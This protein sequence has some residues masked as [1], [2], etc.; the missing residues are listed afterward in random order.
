MFYNQEIEEV[1]QQQQTDAAKGLSNAEVQTRKEKYGPNKLEEGKKKSLVVLFLQQL[2]DPLIFI[3]IIA[4]IVSGILGELNDTIIIA[5]VV[6]LNAILG[7]SQ[8]AKAEKAMEALQKLTSPKAYVVRDGETVEVDSVEIVPGDIVVLDAG[9]YIPCD[10]RLIESINMQVEESALTGESVPVHKNAKLVISDENIPLGDKKNMAF[11]STLVTSGRGMGVAIAI[12]METE[13]GHIANMLKQ[14]DQK[15]PLQKKLADIGKILG[16]I[17]LGVCLAMFLIAVFQHRDIFQMFMIAISLAVAAIPEGMP[18]IVSIVLA[19]GVQ[20]MVKKNAIVRK[21][22]SVETLGAVTV[23][24]SD[25][26]GTLTQ[27]KMTVRKFYVNKKVVAAEEMDINEMT[28]RLLIENLVLCSDATSN[29]EGSTGDP[30][31][32]A[33]INIGNHYDIRKEALTAEHQ[34]IHEAPFDSDRK[35]MS[36]INRYGDKYYVMTKGATDNLLHKSVKALINGEVVPMTDEIRKDFNDAAGKMSDDAL[37]VLGAACKETME[38]DLDMEQMESDLIFLGLVAMIDPPRLEVRDSISTCRNSGII[39]VMITGDHQKTAFAIAK[40]LGIADRPEQTMAGMELDKYSDEELV[41]KV[42][43]IRVF[44]RVSPEH[45]VRIVTAY[46]GGGNI[47]SMTGDGVNDAPSLKAAD[48]GV[49][50]GITGTDVAKGASDL[51]LTDDN[52]STIV[53]AVEEGRNIYANIKKSVMFLLSCNIGE[54]VSL[55]FAVLLGWATPLQSIHLLWVNLI[56]D[57]FPALSLGADPSDPTIMKE[58]PRS[59]KESLFSGRG[60]FLVINGV[61]IGFITLAAFC[62]GGMEYTGV[63]NLSVLHE[64]NMTEDVLRHAQTMAFVVLSVSQLFHALNLRSEKRSIFQV[65]LF[66]NKW[67][68]LSIVAGILIQLIIISVP[69]LAAVFEVHALSV[70]DWALVIG[71]SLVPLILN[72]I[73]KLIRRMRSK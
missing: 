57:S 72:E 34:R 37:R 3:L 58:K 6:I 45:K 69:A 54:I 36:T 2:N 71:L 66:T 63:W 9:R 27:N 64:G 8:E 21:L 42:K 44:A 26:T 28:Q 33:L 41:E 62:I 4:A 14:P 31:E 70:A 52:F 73:A 17:A 49:A 19:I 47:V 38:T 43:D 23:I 59:S 51:I 29:K 53:A 25:K 16:F 13:I 35:L 24:C 65:G 32:I 20:K 48:I 12:G 55:F 50:M 39:T 61:V 56:T 60:A 40:E 18:A 7:L 5:L 15:T 1:I 11:S 22:P 30:T 68:A 46:K 10:I 67:L